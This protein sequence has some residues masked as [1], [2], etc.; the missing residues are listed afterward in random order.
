[1]LQLTSKP[2]TPEILQF[3]KLKYPSYAGVYFL[4]RQIQC[5]CNIVVIQALGQQS[6]DRA[7]DACLFPKASHF[8]PPLD[9]DHSAP[10]SRYL[11]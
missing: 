5:H 1:M 10:E 3:Q 8:M 2:P 7:Q 11:V 6:I 4:L 9:V